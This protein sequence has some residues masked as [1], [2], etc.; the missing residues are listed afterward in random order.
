M[1]LSPR[2]GITT[3]TERSWLPGGAS[4]EPYAEAVRQAGGEPVRLEASL[5]GQELALI[6]SLD[7]FLFP[8]GWD[9]DLRHYPRP[10][11]LDGETPGQRM[12]RRAMR[13]EPARDR[14][15]L[16]LLKAAVDAD[17]PVLGICRGCQ[18]LHVALGGR[19]ILD[20]P[21]EVGGPI[22]HPSFPEPERL[23]SHHALSIAP[24]T[25]LAAIL[26]PDRHDATNSR[27][28]QSVIPD[29][30]TP[31]RVAAICPVDGVV[32]AI[33]APDCRF[34]IGVQWHPEHPKDPEVRAAHRPLFAA[35]VAS[36]SG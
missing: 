6:E 25:R 32:E 10:P 29:D 17:R 36:A 2:I 24:G 8:G 14:L 35:F 34:V 19:L 26:S 3:G 1:V 27:H 18:V 13:T 22:R 21:T 23:S 11:V 16:P 28:H 30:E 20:L 15:E 9:I 7:G 5:A 31:T 12:A 33:E 4:Y